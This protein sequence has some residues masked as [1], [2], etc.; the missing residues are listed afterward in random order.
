M[1]ARETTCSRI[2]GTTMLAAD[3][4]LIPDDED[5]DDTDVG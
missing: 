1:M 3:P 2:I 4:E 5:E